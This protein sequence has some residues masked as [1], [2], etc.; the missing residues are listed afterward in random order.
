M[1]KNILFFFVIFLIGAWAF[2]VLLSPQQTPEKGPSESTPLGKALSQDQPQERKNVVETKEK[3]VTYAKSW[4]NRPLKNEEVKPLNIKK[5]EE[6]NSIASKEKPSPPH[7]IDV[8]ALEQK[9]FHF[10]VDVLKLYPEDA[11]DVLARYQDIL[12]TTNKYP[13]RSKEQ[14]EKISV[15]MAEYEMWL[16]RKLGEGDYLQ[17]VEFLDKAMRE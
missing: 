3:K 15:L 7:A 2:L 16:R 17:Y 6:K 8:E 12:E 14:M 10:L 1:K 4:G 9:K 5:E 11:Q 13:S